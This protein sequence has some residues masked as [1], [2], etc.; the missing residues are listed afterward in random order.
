MIVVRGADIR[1]EPAQL[2]IEALDA[3]LWARFPN[4][5]DAP[6]RRKKRSRRLIQMRSPTVGA[7][8]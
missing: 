7:F 8:A 3:E 2:L 4:R 1:G 5:T 6:L